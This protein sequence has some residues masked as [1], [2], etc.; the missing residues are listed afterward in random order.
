MKL[1]TYDVKG[2]VLNDETPNLRRDLHT[3][4]AYVRERMIKRA[5]R[6]NQLPTIINV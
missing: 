6:S 3:F 5:V 1:T 2:L 4:V